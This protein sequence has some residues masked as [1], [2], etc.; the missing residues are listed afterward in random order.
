MTLLHR[1]ATPLLALLLENAL[2]R[3]FWQDRTLTQQRQRLCNKV[4]RL[5]IIDWDCTFHLL[6]SDAWIDVQRVWEGEVDCTVRLRPTLLPA[7]LDKQQLTALIREGKLEID[8]DIQVAQ[9]LVNLL[10][11]AAIDPAEW[12]TPWLGD[13]GAQ[14]L[15][16]AVTRAARQLAAG[17]H[18]QHR[19]LA[20]ALTEEWRLSPPALEVAW[21]S[22]EVA[23]LAR[24][25][26]QLEQRLARL[27]RKQ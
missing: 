7:L 6:F 5:E 23:A 13:V 22:D 4:L 10:D 27:G 11:A 8:G 2:N 16:Q 19:A 14:G 3:L 9:Q 21:F 12:L 17:A 24:E 20:E 26:Q 25:T 15:H 18:Q 1:E